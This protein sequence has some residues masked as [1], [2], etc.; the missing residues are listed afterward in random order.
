MCNIVEH[1]VGPHGTTPTYS[2]IGRDS[3]GFWRD[4]FEL[5]HFKWASVGSRLGPIKPDDPPK[6]SKTGM[7]EIDLSNYIGGQT[8]TQ[9]LEFM[10][11]FLNVNC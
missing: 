4:R 2:I 5:H 8:T 10:M 1:V 3:G 7:P 6:A 11:A 9:Q